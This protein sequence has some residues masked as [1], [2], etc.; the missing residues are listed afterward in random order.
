MHLRFSLAVAMTVLTASGAALAQQSAAVTMIGYGGLPGRAPQG[1]PS[2]VQLGESTILHAGVGAEA[3]YDTNVYYRPSTGSQGAGILRILP[4]LELTNATRTGDVPSGHFFD[5]S[6]SLL[7]REYLSNQVDSENKRAFMPSVG[8]TVELSGNQTVSMTLSDTFTRTEDPPYFGGGPIIRNAN[9]ALAQ[10]RLTPGGGRLQGLARYTNGI[11]IFDSSSSANSYAYANSMSHELMLDFSW[12]WLPK[13]AIFVQG[14]QGYTQ[15]FNETTPNGPVHPSYPLHVTV[16]LRGLVTE[17]LSLGIAAG[18]ANAFYSDGTST[19]GFWGSTFVSADVAYRPMLMT[20]VTLGYR[21]DFQNS[22]ISNF[23][24][25]DGVYASL[26]QQ[27]LTRISVA[28]SGRWEHRN[29]QGLAA[30]GGVSSRVD[31]FFQV[32]ATVDLS[33]RG[34]FYAG[35]G[36]SLLANSSNQVSMMGLPPPEYLKHQVFGRLGFTY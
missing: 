31:D 19:S 1:S 16:G 35:V 27:L 14:R 25:L 29:F 2:G 28:L 11:D 32:G 4:F 20:L 17:K 26:Q 34:G 22:I 23:Y 6:A 18:Y 10:L 13:T 12:K 5:L 30:T 24:Y 9:L 7:Y 8:G 36:Y 15:Y 3:G 21:H 33:I